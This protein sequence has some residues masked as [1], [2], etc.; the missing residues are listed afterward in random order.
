MIPQLMVVGLTIMK[1]ISGRKAGWGKIPIVG[2]LVRDDIIL[3]SIIGQFLNLVKS[4]FRSQSISTATLA[5]CL[6]PLLAC[7]DLGRNRFDNDRHR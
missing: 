4:P 2:C 5:F 6:G 7:S 1:Y 3:V